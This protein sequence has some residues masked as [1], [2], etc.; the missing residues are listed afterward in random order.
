MDPIYP[1]KIVVPGEPRQSNQ[2]HLSRLKDGVEAWN[3]WRSENYFSLDLSGANLKGADLS[4]ANLAET[5]LTG[6][7]F[8]EATLEGASLYNAL[9]G[10]ADLRGADLNGASLSDAYLNGAYLSGTDLSHAL[11]NDAHLHGADLSGANLSNVTLTRANLTVANLAGA[12]LC[13][14]YLED[15][16]LL[17]TNL[18]GADLTG[19]DLTHARFI[20]TEIGQARFSRCRIYGVSAWDV[21]GIP[22]TQDSLIITPKGVPEVTTDNLKV[23]QF[24]YMILN[25]DE[26]RDVID[27]I[28]KKAVLILGRFGTRKRVLDSI[29]QELRRLDYLPIVFDFPPAASQ[30]T[31][32]TVSTLA[33]LTR[34][35][36]ADLTSAK[37]VIG[38]L[39]RIA[40]ALPE[41]PIQLLLE[42]S[43]DVPPM[44]DSFLLRAN[45]L[46]PFRYTSEANLMKSLNAKVIRPAD[47]KATEF[48]KRL[49]EIRKKHLPGQK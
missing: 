49:A 24:I 17:K 42:Q 36:I 4:G 6:T 48:A 11:I 23:A 34:F 22:D 32:R 45:V 26:I 37:S 31:M 3:R 7:D 27:T 29:R 47:R 2:E 16:N 5:D 14:A 35:V 21:G 39:E 12:S 19:A 15:A 20:G 33:H 30:S 13:D 18:T 25:N 41:L 40:P 46:G 10:N 28:G 9:L 8:R 38:E 1:D 43:D 44:A